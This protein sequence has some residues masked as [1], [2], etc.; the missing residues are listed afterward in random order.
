MSRTMRGAW[1]DTA[2]EVVI[3]DL[4]VPTT[5]PDR[6]LLRTV[7]SALCGSDL[8][9]F[10]GADS[11]GVD[12]DAFGHESVGQVV[13]GGSGR[14][15]PGTLVL[16]TPQPRDGKVFAAYQYAYVD[17]VIPV[18]AGVAAEDALLAQQLGTVL[19]G[20][21]LFW[22][23][24]APP[25]TAFVAGAGPAGLLF[26]LA[27]RRLGCHDI[28][29]SEPVPTRLALARALGARDGAATD[30]DLAIDT[31]GVLD[32]RRACLDALRR[33]GTCGVF[34]LPDDE[35]GDLGLSV[36][37]LMGRNLTVVGAQ[38][39]QSEPGLR[40]FHEALALIADGSFDV[41]PLI[42]HRIDL[43]HL[44]ALTRAAA[45]PDDGVVKVLVTFD[46]EER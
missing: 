28:V 24:E 45:A 20:L 34:G 8:H 4:D 6:L 15:A 23:A 22:K 14:L 27:L 7:V 40:S 5:G 3:R 29:V 32:G 44:P 11:Y 42:S 12:T 25:R 46:S 33:G 17:Y 19:Y 38:G 26:V 10:R 9:R 18:P 13:G 36:L 2:G 30:V 39:T 21:R 16:H 35:P 1:I 41:G 37:E 43:D 31:T